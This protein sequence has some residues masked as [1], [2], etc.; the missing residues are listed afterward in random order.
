MSKLDDR[1]NKLA[2]VWDSRC[3]GPPCKR[4]S[5][6]LERKRGEAFPRVLEQ[7]DIEGQTSETR[8]G[9]DG[10]VLLPKR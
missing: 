7:Q 6:G 4:Q 9:W 5:L 8:L 1:S 10:S 2:K 3:C